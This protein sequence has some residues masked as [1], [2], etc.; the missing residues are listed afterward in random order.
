[1]PI[2]HKIVEGGEQYLGWALQR[3]RALRKLAQD[4]DERKRKRQG[5]GQASVTIVE[6]E[7]TEGHRTAKYDLGDA[8]VEI[9]VVGNHSFIRLTKG[10]SAG[11]GW[12]A[13][14]FSIS[15]QYSAAN[16]W[17]KLTGESP[18]P[19]N[20]GPPPEYPYVPPLPPLDGGVALACASDNPMPTDGEL[21]DYLEYTYDT[22]GPSTQGY[23]MRQEALAANPYFLAGER[24]VYS[25]SNCPM[26]PWPSGPDITFVWVLSGTDNNGTKYY[27]RV[28]SWNGRNSNLEKILAKALSLAAIFQAQA[29]LEAAAGSAWQAAYAAWSIKYNR[30]LSAVNGTPPDP[31]VCYPHKDQVRAEAERNRP[32]QIEA[33]RDEVAKGINS[34]CVFNGAARPEYIPFEYPTDRF[35][36]N[37]GGNSIDVWVGPGSYQTQASGVT[38]GSASDPRACLSTLS[39]DRFSNVYIDAQPQD[40]K[41]MV[42][43]KRTFGYSVTGNVSN[44]FWSIAPDADL[45]LAPTYLAWLKSA[46]TKFDFNVGGRNMDFDLT[47]G[48]SG[49]IRLLF[50]EFKVYDPSTGRWLW[51]PS[52]RL[53]E[54]PAVVGCVTGYCSTI[55]R[56]PPPQPAETPPSEQKDRV[57][58]MRVF[59]A[60]EQEY[61]PGSEA[62]TTKWSNPYPLAIPDPTLFEVDFTGLP[63]D[64]YEAPTGVSVM[65]GVDPTALPAEPSLRSATTMA[66]MTSNP[67]VQPP[68]SAMDVQSLTEW[69]VKEGTNAL[70][71][72]QL[73]PP[74]P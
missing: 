61:S 58:A 39:V 2:I 19:E 50:F 1:M 67:P 4:R 30:W 33:L 48:R 8:E 59:A 28:V 5:E 11:S 69:L 46:R 21:G 55:D 26:V 74:T 42:T 62:G 36:Q 32:I 25:T 41:R 56:T 65:Y 27:G 63:Y 60:M 51:T 47:V 66:H 17:P 45:E 29:E 53:F 14:P 31:A 15:M 22:S 72:A 24:L 38:P 70:L 54:T 52:P 43:T 35:V 34:L 49:R 23:Q 71:T 12:V 13:Y 37:E 7:V 20:P 16:N 3:E 9:R 18:L 10:G 6:D 44:E 57:S 64:R 68:G 73:A 40:A